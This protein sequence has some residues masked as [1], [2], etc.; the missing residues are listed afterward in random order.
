MELFVVGLNILENY[1][2][3]GFNLF[4]AFYFSVSRTISFQIWERTVLNVLLLLDISSSDVA[5]SIVTNMG[6]SF[7]HN[8][9]KIEFT[10]INKK[11]HS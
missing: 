10:P 5:L 9:N 11:T 2:L 6:F 4:G 7:I 3:D 1:K 8:L